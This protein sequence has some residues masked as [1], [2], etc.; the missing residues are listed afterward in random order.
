MYDVAVI[1]AGPAG[2]AA[3][4]K[5]LEQGARVLLLDRFAFPRK[6]ACAG[7]LTPKAYNLFPYDISAQVR[8]VCHTVRVSRPNGR[9]FHIREDRPLC[10]MTRREDLDLLSLNKAVEKGAV[11][12]QVPEIRSINEKKSCVEVQAGQERFRALFLIGADGANSRV[13]RFVGGKN[14]WTNQMALEA[15]IR[16][17]R[18]DQYDMELDFSRIRHGY[19]WIFPRDDH[20]NIGMYATVYGPGPRIGLLMEYSASR[21]PSGR[22]TGVRGYPIGTGG[23][24]YRPHTDRI[25]LAGDAAGMAEPLLGEGIYFAIKSGQEAAMAI[26]E[27]EDGR[28]SAKDAYIR[29]LRPVQMDLKGYTLAGACLYRLPGP[30]LGILSHPFVHGPFAGGYAAGRTLTRIFRVP[31]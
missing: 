4:F 24:A 30:W 23:C 1:G 12:R 26:L 18:V 28:V 20:V 14:F 5:L 13:R 21:F 11:F 25:L 31:L 7:G 27:A 8:R 16:L 19:F 6:K 22:L 29:R 9:S 10:H 3:A 2:T 17:D 15:D